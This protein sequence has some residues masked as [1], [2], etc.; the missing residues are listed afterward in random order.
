[1][2]AQ[3]FTPA[4]EKRRRPSHAPGTN[5]RGQAAGP[6]STSGPSST[7]ARTATRANGAVPGDRSASAGE[8]C[9]EFHADADRIARAQ[10]HLVTLDTAGTLAETFR[11]L[12]DPTRVRLLDAL[13]T[14]EMCVCDLASL[15]GHT[16]SAV[17][18][19]LRLL[20]G[21]R[22]VRARRAGRMVFYTLDDH[23]IISL[24]TQARRHAEEEDG[25]RA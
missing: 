10:A 9:A 24:L 23:H 5:P 4:R 15:L 7:P 13:S 16:V 6:G 25:A 14:G 17:S 21:V 22:L 11:L 18:H 1:M 2:P 20:R 3:V 19:Q 8:A 12:G